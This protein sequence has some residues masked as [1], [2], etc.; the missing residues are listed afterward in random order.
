MIIVTVEI[1]VLSAQHSL[2]LLSFLSML[3]LKSAKENRKTESE[4]RREI[5]CYKAGVQPRLYLRGQP[6][7]M[8]NKIGGPGPPCL[9]LCK[10]TKTLILLLFF[11]LIFFSH[12][13]L[14]SPSYSSCYS[15]NLTWAITDKIP[16]TAINVATSSLV[17][18]ITC[19][20]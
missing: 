7:K 4:R 20:K 5:L 17:K 6:K 8:A 10:I 14:I 18:W 16:K 2:I 1:S 15:F 9:H 19:G 13:S 11:S 3:G 12:S